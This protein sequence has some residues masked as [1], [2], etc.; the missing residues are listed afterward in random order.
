MYSSCKLTQRRRCVLLPCVCVTSSSSPFDLALNFA[1]F[2]SAQ[3]R[4]QKEFAEFDTN[5]DGKLTL[6]EYQEESG[7]EVNPSLEVPQKVDYDNTA[8]VERV[9]AGCVGVGLG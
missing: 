6:K 1:G 3:R 9:S 2:G 8:E 7:E 5:K 4:A